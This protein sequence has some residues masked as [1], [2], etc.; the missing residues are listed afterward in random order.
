MLVVR[1]DIIGHLSV[2]YFLSRLR[3]VPRPPFSAS[4]QHDQVVED[5]PRRDTR[6]GSREAERKRG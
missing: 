4:A 6:V 2:R 3:G 1:F 5:T